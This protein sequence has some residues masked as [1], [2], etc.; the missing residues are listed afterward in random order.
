MIR[1]PLIIFIFFCIS[2]SAVSYA[3]EDTGS[4]VDYVAML[5]K[6]SEQDRD[7]SLNAAP[8][9]R[10]AAELYVELPEEIK[11][12]ELLQWPTELPNSHLIKVIKQWI[13]S[14]SNAVAQLRLGIQ[15]PYFWNQY[16]AKTVFEAGMEHNLRALRFVIS[17]TLFLGKLK[18]IEQGM[19]REVVENFLVC[20]RVGSH[21]TQ[22]FTTIEQTLGLWSVKNSIQTLFLCLMKTDYNRIPIVS[23][24]SSIHE[25]FSKIQ[26]QTFSL[27]AEKLLHLEVVQ[28]LFQGTNDDSK[29]KAEEEMFLASRMG[30][31]TYEE[32]QAVRRGKT[33]QDLAV[34]HAYCKDFLSMSPWQAK[35]KGL[36]FW[37]DI[38]TKTGGNP[39]VIFC[40]IKVPT[41]N[42]P[43]VVRVIAHGNARRD[44]LLATL[45][46]IKYRQDKGRFPKDL[47]ELLATD[48][49]S[50]L[51][52]DPYSNG[53][54]IY[55][56]TGDDFLLYSLGEDFD[57]DGGTHS[58]WGRD[59]QGGDY[60]FWPIQTKSDEKDE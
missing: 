44:A 22:A 10:K 6:L 24:Q 32:L 49:L 33:L 59:E 16:K 38:Y 34:A 4:K 54:L 40:M 21:L 37:D 18:V 27:E 31:L 39:V 41:V 17:A 35:E 50:Q 52:M 60:V 20:T 56:Q 57:D 25:Q 47:Q 9:Y 58:N 11:Y 1:L 29:L 55:K 14:N 23:L 42:V 7:E 26:N 53:P 46:L 28:L 45:S 43:G 51:P 30:G 19:T 8:F 48:Y 12:Q 3:G 36:N 13:Q 2:V 5:N 15:K